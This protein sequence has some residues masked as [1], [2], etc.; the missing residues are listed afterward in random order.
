MSTISLPK[1]LNKAA[2]I[3]RKNHLINNVELP[4]NQRDAACVEFV[5]YG[6]NNET[7]KKVSQ[8]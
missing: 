3:D 5:N 1:K 6:I 2:D 8:N 4:T 7:Q